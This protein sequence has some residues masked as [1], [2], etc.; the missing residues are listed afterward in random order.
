M[1]AAWFN[2]LGRPAKAHA[3]SAGTDPGT[4]VHPEVVGPCAKLASISRRLDDQADA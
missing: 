2:R 3:I 1:A 4:R